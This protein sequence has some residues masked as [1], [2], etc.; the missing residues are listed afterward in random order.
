M[1]QITVDRSLNKLS[2]EALTGV[3]I[4]RAELMTLAS[5]FVD[6]ESLLGGRGF[7]TIAL[8]VP[9]VRA[10][11]ELPFDAR[12]FIFQWEIFRGK[13]GEIWRSGIASII[14]HYYN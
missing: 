5:F 1:K 3:Q 9:L 6:G 10:R 7:V 8:Q 11:G 12:T 2:I 4:G 14:L 13:I